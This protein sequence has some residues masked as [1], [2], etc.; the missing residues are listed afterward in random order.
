MKHT[1]LEDGKELVT[2]LD[3]R[4]TLLLIHEDILA[5]K[6][7]IFSLRTDLQT[8]INSLRNSMRWQIIVPSLTL[9][10]SLIIHYILK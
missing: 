3:L 7:E 1:E 6:K 10:V 8:Q 9:V 4:E 2:R 5:I